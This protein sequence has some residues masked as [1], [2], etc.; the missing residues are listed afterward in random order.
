LIEFGFLV[1]KKIFS[2]YFYSFAIISPWRRVI[3]LHLNKV[4]SPLPI[5]GCFVP[6]LVKIGPMVLEK[7][8]FK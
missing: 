6:S 2:V 3:P 8:I 7:K 4:E 1:L 5:E